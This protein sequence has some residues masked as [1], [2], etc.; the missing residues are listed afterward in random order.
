MAIRRFIRNL[1]N[2][3]R[4]LTP[5]EAYELWAPTYDERENNAVL[6]TEEQ[7]ILPIF[8]RI[9][10]ANKRVVDF[11]CGTGRHILHCL[12]RNAREIVGIDISDAMLSEARR[13][14]KDPRVLFVQSP[15]DKLPLAEVLFDVGIASLVLSHLQV[16]GP[17]IH[18]MARVMRP[19][20]KLLVSDIHWK[21]NERRWQRTFH[22]RNAPTQRVAP[23]NYCHSLAGYED[24]FRQNHLVV[25]KFSEPPLNSSLR[26][27]FERSNMIEVYERYLGEPLL[28]VFEVRKR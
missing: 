10:M 13:K 2:P 17:S 25:D 11:G 24:A 20:A 26:P 14:I 6:L 7:A 16:L 8:D 4:I 15:L 23:E 21:F 27:C 28:V 5:K 12:D 19:R 1:V 9:Q 18:E 22:P 3:V